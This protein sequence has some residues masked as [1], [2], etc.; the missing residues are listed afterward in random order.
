[1][2]IYHISYIY[3][4]HI[5]FIYI[6]VLYIIYMYIYIYHIPYI[7]IFYHLYI[8]IY[9][10]GYISKNSFIYIYHIYFY[11]YIYIYLSYTYVPPARQFSLSLS[12][13]VAWRAPHTKCLCS[14]KR[15]TSRL[16]SIGCIWRLFEGIQGIHTYIVYGQVMQ[17]VVAKVCETCA[18]N[19]V[20]CKEYIGSDEA[21][22]IL[23]ICVSIVNNI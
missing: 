15:F 5:S 9:I 11:L 8:C 10:Y 4:Y 16:Q 3:I 17:S 2:Y 6:Y 19:F 23:H 18:G 22:H 7:Y 13:L 21:M 20:E 1:M 12:P 14:S